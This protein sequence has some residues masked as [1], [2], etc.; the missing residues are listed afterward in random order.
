VTS[1]G[2]RPS[3]ET[4]AP[5]CPITVRESGRRRR[6][7]LVMSLRHG[8]VLVVPRGFDRGRVP[9]ILAQKRRWIERAAARSDTYRT[10]LEAEAS[11]FPDRLELRSIGEMWTVDYQQRP[12]SSITT[13]RALPGSRLLVSGRADDA[14][15]CQ[16]ALTR[17]L[18][19]RARAALVPLL[20]GLAAEHGFEVKSVRVGAQRTVW[21]TCA[22]HGT[23][24]LN[25]KLLFLP[26]E[27]S[28][29]VL[30]HELCHT[31][32][33]GHGPAF[34]ALLADRDPDMERKRRLMRDAW[35]YIPA[36]LEAA[37]RLS[38]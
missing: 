32:Q 3:G 16:A 12:R 21:G 28:D 34:W 8:L 4:W 31:R 30:V 37:R 1:E 29:Y 11:R 27:L 2:S 13:A 9:E 7:R 10:W 25:M 20:L 38:L 33:R 23:I 22:R 26:A 14:A 5:A 19:R 18:K 24:S 6:V 35:G 15:A 36:W 17:W